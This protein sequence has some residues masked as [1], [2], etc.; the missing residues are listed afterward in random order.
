MSDLEELA[1]KDSETCQL[2]AVRARRDDAVYANTAEVLPFYT[3]LLKETKFYYLTL[4][5]RRHSNIGNPW[6]VVKRIRSDFS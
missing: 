3:L 6:V 2:F 1:A 5:A 4:D